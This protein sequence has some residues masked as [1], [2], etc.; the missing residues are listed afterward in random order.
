MRSREAAYKKNERELWNKF[1]RC[2]SKV[3]LPV[4]LNRRLF[5]YIRNGTPDASA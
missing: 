2:Y 3:A 1:S 5:S 4:T